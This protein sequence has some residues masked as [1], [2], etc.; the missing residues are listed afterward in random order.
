MPCTFAEVK[1][2]TIH[3]EKQSLNTLNS[4]DAKTIQ[5]TH[6]T[7]KCK[8]SGTYRVQSSDVWMIWSPNNIEMVAAFSNEFGFSQRIQLEN[9]LEMSQDISNGFLIGSANH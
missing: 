9:P 8:Y 5:W 3:R 2:F 6:H 4:F 1:V 7:K